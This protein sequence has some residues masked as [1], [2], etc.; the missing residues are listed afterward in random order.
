[1]TTS[2]PT[3]KVLT[4]LLSKDLLVVMHEVGGI[5]EVLDA[6]LSIPLWAVSSAINEIFYRAVFIFVHY[7][8]IKQTVYLKG[9]DGIGVTVDKHGGWHV[10]AG[11]IEEIVSRGR[12]WLQ[13]NYRENRIHSQIKQNIQLVRK[14]AYFLKYTKRAD[15]L[16]DELLCN[17]GKRRDRVTLI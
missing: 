15:V 13:L 7:L 9:F 5:V 1:M 17:A 4:P 12:Y 2:P 10:R 14:L 3:R 11:A 16:L 6:V 8:L